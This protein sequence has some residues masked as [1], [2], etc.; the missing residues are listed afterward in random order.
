MELDADSS[1]VM[2]TSAGCNALDYLLDNPAS[3]A[4]IDVN[5]RQNALLELKQAIFKHGNHE[6]LFAFFGDGRHPDAEK[7][8]RTEIRLHLNE[9]SQAFWDKKIKYFAR[10]E[11][12]KSFYYRGTSGSLA[13]FFRKYLNLRPK[14]KQLSHDLLAATQLDKQAT[15]YQRLEPELL[16]YAI[17]WL[18]GRH[19][20]MALAGVPR[21]QRELLYRFDG[22]V[23]GFVQ[24][25]LN[26]VFTKLPITD[27]YFWRVYLEGCY[28]ETC[29]PNYLVK[30]HFETLKNRVSNIRTYTT[31]ISQ[32]LKDNPAE[33]SHYVL[34]D[35]Q[36]WLAAHNVAA[37][38][39]EWTLILKNSRKGTRLLLRSAAPEVDFF[40]DFVNK[41]VEWEKTKTQETHFNDRV[42]TYGCVYL[43]IVK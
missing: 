19:V 5:P 23:G 30:S 10:S 43:G 20:T 16:T 29:C 1:I 8:Y 15:I 22:G 26:H 17:K 37:L 9:E 41:A 34:L 18:M 33:Y 3:I 25:A 40:P 24:N 4:C 32:F 2:I 38:E 7:V 35:H 13:W 6:L 12:K 31:T 39:E 42:G 36:D 21:P 28:T 27:N 11:P 14:T